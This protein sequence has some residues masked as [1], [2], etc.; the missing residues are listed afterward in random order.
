MFGRPLSSKETP[1]KLSVDKKLYPALQ[2]AANGS[3]VALGKMRRIPAVE[4]PGRL[5]QAFS[6]EGSIRLTVVS[7]IANPI[8]VGFSKHLQLL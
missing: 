4:S 3:S 8:S 6:D 1:G 7:P 2:A 5:G